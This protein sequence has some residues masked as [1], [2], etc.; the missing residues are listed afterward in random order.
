MSLK[1]YDTNQRSD[2]L[3]REF[4]VFYRESR[5][6]LKYTT[7]QHLIYAKYYIVFTHFL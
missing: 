2:W 3:P 5:H 1:K 4:Y 6:T 7:S